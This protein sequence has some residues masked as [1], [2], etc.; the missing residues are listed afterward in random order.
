MSQSVA[1][2]TRNKQPVNITVRYKLD[3]SIYYVFFLINDSLY[4]MPRICLNVF[5]LSYEP[6][7]QDTIQISLTL[8]SKKKKVIK[9]ASLVT[10]QKK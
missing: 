10:W 8:N 1:L 2:A 6:Y 9:C 5:I 4:L 3:A 7:V